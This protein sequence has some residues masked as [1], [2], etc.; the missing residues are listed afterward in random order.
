MSS[1]N[2]GQQEFGVTEVL[3][4]GNG[5][6]IQVYKSPETV[7][8][9]S[10]GAETRTLPR[11]TRPGT[12][13]FLYARALGGNIVLTVPGGFNVAGTTTFTFSA[14]GHFCEFVSIFDGTNYLWRLTSHHTIGNTAQ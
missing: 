7:A 1:H 8:L 14:V 13:L 11:P 9:T 12:R 2:I 4:P 3:D 10:A 6:A 5:G